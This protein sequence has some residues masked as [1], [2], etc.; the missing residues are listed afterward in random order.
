MADPYRWLE[1]DRAEDTKD[2]VQREVAFY[3]KLS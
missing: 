3:T 1:D 2:W